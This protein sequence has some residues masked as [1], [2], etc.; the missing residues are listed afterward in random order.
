MRPSRE[1]CLHRESIIPWGVGDAIPARGAAAGLVSV[2]QGGTLFAFGKRG[3]TLFGK[4]ERLLV[5]IHL[6]R[7]M[8]GILK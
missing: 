3:V 7:I 4:A 1:T 5:L 6:I 8:G 2:P